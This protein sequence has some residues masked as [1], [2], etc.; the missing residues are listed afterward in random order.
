MLKKLIFIVDEKIK[1]PNYNNDVEIVRKNEMDENSDENRESTLYVCD[2]SKVAKILCEQ[3]KNVVALLTDENSN[4]DFS[5]CKYAIMMG[6]K[7]QWSQFIFVPWGKN[8]P[9]SRSKPWQSPIFPA[10]CRKSCGKPGESP[11]SPAAMCIF[12]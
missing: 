10:M 4:Q 7:S 1:L 12:P 8:P 5:F 6:G 9:R 2:D 11:T 3:D